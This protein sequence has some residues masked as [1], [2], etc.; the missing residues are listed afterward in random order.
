VALVSLC[1][2]AYA[3]S[4][5]KKT[6]ET[7]KTL[8]GTWE[9]V[10]TTVP[11]TPE[12]DG[13]IMT[14]TLRVTSMGH[15]LM[16]EMTAPGRPDDPITMLYVEDDRLMLMHFCDAN[17]RPRMSGKVSEDG[18]SVEFEFLDVTGNMKHGHMHRAK[19]NF[20]DADHHTEDWMFM[21]PGDQVFHAHVELKRKQ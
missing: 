12:M 21:V 14:V 3:Q 15:T 20:I 13:K 1:T 16:H 9:G 8:A 5:S 2:V 7:L 4:D 11:K 18:K 19:F 10:I 17:N 6:F